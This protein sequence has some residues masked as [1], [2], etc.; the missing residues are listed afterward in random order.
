MPSKLAQT[1]TIDSA[2]ATQRVT[3]IF[4]NWSAPSIYI[5]ILYCLTENHAAFGAWCEKDIYHFQSIKHALDNIAGFISMFDS[6]VYS[7]RKA[8]KVWYFSFKVLRHL[9]FASF[10]FPWHRR[11]LVIRLKHYQLRVELFATKGFES[12]RRLPISCFVV[13]ISHVDKS[14]AYNTRRS[15]IS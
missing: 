11:R 9:C 5:F 13:N 1:A 3:E 4:L 6:C 2:R 14:L 12:G 8:G 7:V 10:E 15:N